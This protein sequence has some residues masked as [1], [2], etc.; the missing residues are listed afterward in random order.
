MVCHTPNAWNMSQRLEKIIQQAAVD[1]S[2]IPVEPYHYCSRLAWPF[3][4]TLRETCALPRGSTVVPTKQPTG[5]PQAAAAGD[6][7]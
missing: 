2:G 5:Y 6:A 7:V 3:S 1:N 4:A